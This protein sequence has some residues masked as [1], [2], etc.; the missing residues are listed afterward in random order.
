MPIRLRVD[1]RTRYDYEQ[2]VSLSPHLVRLFPR[3]EP[4]RLVQSLKFTTNANASVQYRRDLFDNNF[5]RCF[6]P[7][8][9]QGLFF[10]FA[11][12][13]ELHE[14]NAFDFLLD[15][16]AV[17]HPFAYPAGTAARA[18]HLHGPA[19]WRITPN[20]PRQAPAAR[21]LERTHRTQA[22]PFRCSSTCSTPS[23]R[24]SATNSAR[25]A[26]HARRWKRCKSAAVP[27][28]TRASCWPPSCVNSASPPGW[29]AGTCASSDRKRA[30][31]TPKGPC[32]S[33]PRFTCPARA[34]WVSIR[35]TAS[36]ATTVTSRPP[37]GLTT[38][39]VT[40]TSG[41]YYSPVVVPAHMT[42][43]LKLTAL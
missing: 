37:S 31:A 36:F 41:S 5:A 16:F 40:P 28:G 15:N 32:T 29:P 10:D 13:I 42:A 39:D 21:L 33:G 22:P 34:G 19:P 30:T 2:P 3:T 23:T 25:K 11:L 24:T 1:H 43:T 20:R 8:K 26:R 9:L 4:G 12:E 35:R 6:Y 14:Q 18:G 7:D 17:N 27:A 38:A